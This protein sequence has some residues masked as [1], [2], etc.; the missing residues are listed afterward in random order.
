[1]TEPFGFGY[2]DDARGYGYR[3]YSRAATGEGTPHP[4]DPAREFCVT[5][6]VKT[7]IDIGCAKGFL[8]E[9]LLAAGIRTIGFDLSSYALSFAAG[10]PCSRSDLREGLPER[11]EA[12][13]ALGVLVYLGEHELLQVLH[14]LFLN[15]ERFLMVSNYHAGEP[16]TVPDP[17]RRITR[18]RR[19]WGQR[20]TEA[21]FRFEDQGP[22][23]DVYST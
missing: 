5:R 20:I 16:Q 14:D 17:L 3:G 10:L 19:W 22:A 1:L 13:F 11:A 7:A 12:V 4:W 2:F 18:S 23:F 21:G 6:G 15:T 8:V 9:E